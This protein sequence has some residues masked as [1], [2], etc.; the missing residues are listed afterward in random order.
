MRITQFTLEMQ[1]ELAMKGDTRA[2]MLQA[3]VAEVLRETMTAFAN[4][5]GLLLDDVKVDLQRVREVRQA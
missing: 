3:Q 5:R 4:E 1:C 2:D